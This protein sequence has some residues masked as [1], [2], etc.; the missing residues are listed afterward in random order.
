MPYS[1]YPCR[2]PQ[3]CLRQGW[4]EPR[5]RSIA[6]FI[7]WYFRARLFRV[8]LTLKKRLKEAFLTKSLSFLRSRNNNHKMAD[9]RAKRV[10]NG[11]NVCFR[12]FSWHPLFFFEI[13]K[14]RYFAPFC[15]FFALRKCAEEHSKCER[16]VKTDHFLRQIGGPQTDWRAGG[17][18]L[19][20]W[21]RRRRRTRH[22]V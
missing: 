12:V 8:F 20:V 18:F 10:P 7:F 16:G 6:L 4:N 13:A 17:R 1:P 11:T 19:F 5:L 9:F 21:L 3:R 15:K 14:W 2:L 22:T